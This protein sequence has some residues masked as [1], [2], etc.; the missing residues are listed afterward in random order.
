[1]KSARTVLLCAAVI[2]GVY[3]ASAEQRGAAQQQTP[4]AR[5]RATQNARPAQPPAPKPAVAHA[6]AQ[7]DHNAVVRRYCGGCHSDKVKSG[8][9]TLASFDIAHAAQNAE[10]AE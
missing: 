4:A 6:S 5:P 7:P 10:V 2:G 3:L 9:L 1:M 8:G